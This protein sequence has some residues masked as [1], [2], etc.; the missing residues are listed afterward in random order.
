TMEQAAAMINGPYHNILNDV[1]APLQRMSDQT[2][3]RF[4]AKVIKL[5]PG[6][7]GQSQINAEAK[8][9]LI[10]LL[11]VTAFVLV[12]AC[13]NIANL[14]LARAANRTGEMAVRLS[15]GANRRQLV[16]QLLVESC[17][18][19]A[20]GG[21]VGLV[22]AQWTLNLIASLIPAEVTMLKYELD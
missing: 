9:P 22:V 19:A 7:R 3:T 13:S 16:T 14:L 12:I 21:V 20:F 4:K 6:N 1:E 15:I 8:V 2:L 17:V 18:L 5:D 11:G 10:L